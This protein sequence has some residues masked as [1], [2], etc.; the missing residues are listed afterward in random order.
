VKD[1][2]KRMAKGLEGDLSQYY[3]VRS[4]ALEA[5]RRGQIEKA[6][7]FAQ[8]AATF[9]WKVHL[10]IWWDE[11]LENLLSL[12]GRKI[13]RVRSDASSR[14]KVNLSIGHVVTALGIGGHTEAVKQ[15][16]DALRG[17]CEQYLYLTNATNSPQ[18]KI[19]WLENLKDEGV[20]VRSLAYNDSFVSRIE[21]LIGYLERDSPKK[22]VLH[23][24]PNDVVAV[25]ALNGLG[26]RPYVLFF[27]HADTQFWLGRNV[28]DLLIEWRSENLRYSRKYRKIENAVVIPLTV[29]AKPRTRSKQ[30]LKKEIG[31]AH[32]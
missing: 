13:G 17:T 9:A 24:H 32:V 3:W 20:K 27:N 5:Y 22:L 8:V 1:D 21:Q 23:I 16:I 30:S 29:D 6:L 12:V 26:K 25:A 2:E 7:D 28:I 31:R 14:K 15:W 18:S 4:K 10:G 11:D 19:G